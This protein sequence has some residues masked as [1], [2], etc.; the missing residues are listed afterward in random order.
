MKKKITYLD[1]SVVIP[2][3]NSSS[4]IIETL[5]SIKKQIY[6]IQEIIIIDNASTDTSVKLVENYAKQNR[7]MHI[8]LLKNK[9]DLMIARSL[10]RG[11]REA[12]TS[13][14]VLTHSDCKFISSKEIQKLAKPFLENEKIVATYGQVK[15]SLATW[16]HYSFWEK[17]LFAYQAGKTIPGLVGKVDCIN[18]MAYIKS[19]GHDIKG[20]DNYGGEDADLH[21]RL[22]K[23]GQTQETNATIDHLHYMFA[24]F[25]FKDLLEKKQQT[26][27]AYGILLRDYGLRNGLLGLV[28]FLL[29]PIFAI[30]LLIPIINLP[31]FIAF[32]FLTFFYYN[33]MLTT[34]STLFDLRIILVPF[35]ALFLIYYETFWTVAA[36][37]KS[38]K[39]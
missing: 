24:D 38:K 15:Q 7:N 5:K 31:I 39:K 37:V 36:F 21:A 22:R 33:R 16:Y 13:F 8:R 6:P 18:K 14:V 29:K 34:P 1:I 25:S 32:I 30:G 23:I 19:G 20:H 2:M 27:G 17:F 35:A 3:K 28:T 10:N 4:T 26:A 12:K 11:I 9:K